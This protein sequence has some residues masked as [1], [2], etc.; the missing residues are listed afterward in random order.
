[1]FI[2][3]AGVFVSKLTHSVHAYVCT[4]NNVSVFGSRIDMAMDELAWERRTTMEVMAGHTSA[5]DQR[6]RSVPRKMSSL[7]PART[8]G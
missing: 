1:M 2:F 6:S 8:S 4:R 5:M 3:S 7:Y